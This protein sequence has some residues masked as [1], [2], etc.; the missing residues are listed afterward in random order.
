MQ[1]HHNLNW[2]HNSLILNEIGKFFYIVDC[3]LDL[4]Y[5][6]LCLDYSA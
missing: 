3:L 5:M 6:D 1:A 2:M 4:S